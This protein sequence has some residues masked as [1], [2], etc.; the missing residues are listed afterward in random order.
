MLN[1]VNDVK[2]YLGVIG[3]V[4]GVVAMIIAFSFNAGGLLYEAEAL[5]LKEKGLEM[6]KDKLGMGTE[7]VGR[8]LKID[9]VGVFVLSVIAVVA[10]LVGLFIKTSK[11]GKG[12]SWLGYFNINGAGLCFGVVALFWSYVLIAILIAVVLF[13]FSTFLSSFEF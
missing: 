5:S 6:V 8:E 12:D 13:V 2:S 3:L 10:S 1:R 7:K 11:S 4:C 9:H